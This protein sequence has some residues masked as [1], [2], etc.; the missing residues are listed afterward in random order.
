MRI[1]KFM[2]V[3]G[4]GP[5]PGKEKE[6]NEWYHKHITDLFAFG[7]LKRVSR[8]K[9][10]EPLGVDEFPQPT[11]MYLTIYEFDAAEDLVAFYD[12]PLMVDAKKH[13]LEEAPKSVEIY[14]AGFYE[15]VET[16]DKE[17]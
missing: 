10:Y 12:H 15:P 7:G 8:S 14:W 1:N 9:C 6:Y 16:Y 13:Y 5:K 4:S 17:S 11:P 3:V 2:E